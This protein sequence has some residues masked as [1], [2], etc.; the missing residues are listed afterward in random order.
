MTDTKPESTILKVLRENWIFIMFLGSLIV[1]W[2][3]LDGRLTA[4]EVE[5]KR[6][7]AEVSSLSAGVASLHTDVARIAEGIEFIKN[8]LVDR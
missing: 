8:Y 1:G 6:Q 3:Q 5:Q 2:T 7:S 4:V